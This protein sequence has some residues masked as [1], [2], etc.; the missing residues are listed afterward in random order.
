[1]FIVTA[2][3]IKRSVHFKSFF[4]KCPPITPNNL[5][6]RS[7]VTVGFRGA[8]SATFIVFRPCHKSRPAFWKSRPACL[9]S[10]AVLL[11]IEIGL[12]EIKTGLPEMPEIK[13]GLP[14][15]KTC[16][17][18]IENGLLQ[19]EARPARTQADPFKQWFNQLFRLNRTGKNI[20]LS[21]VLAVP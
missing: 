19:I 2:Q 15:I 12:P 18:E 21:C 13:T 1:M 4:R 14:E 20:P 10:R 9:K 11:E 17:P 6:W 8:L 16:R 7:R 5:I 3:L